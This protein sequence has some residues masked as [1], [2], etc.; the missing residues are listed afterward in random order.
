MDEGHLHALLQIT[1]YAAHRRT[2]RQEVTSLPRVISIKSPPMMPSHGAAQ[3]SVWHGGWISQQHAQHGG[4]GRDEDY[5]ETAI[6]RKHQK[7]QRADPG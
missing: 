3:V 6:G 7:Q 4:D 1:N 2:I 5:A